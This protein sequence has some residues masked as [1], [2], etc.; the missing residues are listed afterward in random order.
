M[1]EK[2]RFRT[3]SGII[4]GVGSKVLT[5]RTVRMRVTKREIWRCLCHRKRSRD[6]S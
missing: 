2:R 6:R 4:T 5:R 3:R 1:R